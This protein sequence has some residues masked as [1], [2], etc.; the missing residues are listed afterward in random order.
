M[1]RWPRLGRARGRRGEHLWVRSCLLRARLSGEPGRFAVTHGH[2]GMPA[3]TA[4]DPGAARRGVQPRA[5]AP[6][7]RIP[8]EQFGYIT[9][10][11][12]WPIFDR[13]RTHTLFTVPGN[14]E[15]AVCGSTVHP[16]G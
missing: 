11:D 10:F 14:S 5:L 7:E 13:L 12:T 9:R 6:A 16:E 1:S 2:A 15:L 4:A 8:P 3:A